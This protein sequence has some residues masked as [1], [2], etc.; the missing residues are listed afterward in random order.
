MHTCAGGVTYLIIYNVQDSTHFLNT[1]PDVFDWLSDH[2]MIFSVVIVC[3]MLIYNILI[4][5][6]SYY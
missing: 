5:I 1:L 3:N 2:L 6:I 4:I